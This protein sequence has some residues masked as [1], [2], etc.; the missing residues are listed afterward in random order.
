MSDQKQSLSST[1]NL[2]LFAVIGAVIMPLAGIILG[3]ISLSQMKKGQIPSTNRV[4]AV[5]ALAIGYAFT[6]FYILFIIFQIGA[7][8]YEL[9]HPGTWD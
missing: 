7:F 1:A 8:I 6:F 3:H 4:L 2:P 9:D 5:S